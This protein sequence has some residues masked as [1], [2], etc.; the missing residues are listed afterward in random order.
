MKFVIIIFN[1]FAMASCFFA[2]MLNIKLYLAGVSGVV[3]FIT[4]FF[5][6]LIVGI[7]FAIDSKFKSKNMTPAESSLFLFAG[8]WAIIYPTIEYQEF[9]SFFD[10]T[11]GQLQSLL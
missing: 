5:I 2:S 1:G 4:W 9:S 11:V 8:M 7:I 6:Y 3:E 10:I